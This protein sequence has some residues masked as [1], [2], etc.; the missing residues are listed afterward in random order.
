MCFVKRYACK[1]LAQ[2]MKYLH[3][4]SVQSSPGDSGNV[5]WGTWSHRALAEGRLHLL[6]LVYRCW[7]VTKPMQDARCQGHRST[8][9]VNSLLSIKRWTSAFNYTVTLL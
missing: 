4:H 7:L 1:T 8:E 9:A 5:Q 6:P 3:P 2:G